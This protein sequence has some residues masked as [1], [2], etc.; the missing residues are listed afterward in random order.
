MLV[1][2]VHVVMAHSLLGFE[3]VCAMAG[4]RKKQQ[5]DRSSQSESTLKVVQP[6]SPLGCIS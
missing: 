1:S 4:A 5:C 3:K 6:A 2:V